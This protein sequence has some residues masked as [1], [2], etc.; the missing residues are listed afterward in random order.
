MKISLSTQVDAPPAVVYAR[1]TDI[2]NFAETVTG[3]TRIEVLTPGPTAVGTRFRETRVMFGK[4][5]SETLEVTSL[6][7]DRSMVLGCMSCG[8]LYRSEFRF[9]P[10]EGGTRATLEVSSK[11]VT[12]MARLMVPVGLLMKKCM[13][14]MMDKDLEDL[15]AAAERDAAAR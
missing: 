12:F 4:E 5:H 13:V 15:K 1:A 11:P 6:D 7:P 3:I 10:H 2:A 8:A 9:E 14:S